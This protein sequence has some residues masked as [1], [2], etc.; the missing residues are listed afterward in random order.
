MRMRRK[1]NLDE[2][3]IECGDYY[4][5]LIEGTLDLRV[6]EENLLNVEEM[7]GRNAPILLEIGCGKGAF[8]IELAKRFPEY[9][10]IAVE[11]CKNVILT[12]CQNA[13]AEEIP[14]LRFLCGGAEY[15]HRHLKN[16]CAERIFLNFSASMVYDFAPPPKP[17]IGNVALGLFANVI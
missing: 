14:N 2:H 17:P 1:K 16:G 9:N 12:A 3:L 5:E 7:F 15:L 10:V 8:A 4:T 13:K 6:Q 11:K